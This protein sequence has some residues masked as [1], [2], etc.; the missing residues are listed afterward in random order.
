MGPV[1]YK[2]PFL[3][4]IASKIRPDLRGLS[5][6][7]SGTMVSPMMTRIPT[8]VIALAAIWVLAA[9]LRGQN[10]ARDVVVDLKSWQVDEIRQL[11]TLT[12]S[13]EQWDGIRKDF[14]GCPKRFD[15]VYPSDYDDCACGRT[16]ISVTQVNCSQVRVSL[17]LLRHL[18]PTGSLKRALKRGEDLQLSVDNRGQFYFGGNLV[19]FHQLLETIRDAQGEKLLPPPK[20]VNDDWLVIIRVPIELPEDSPVLATRLAEVESQISEIGGRSWVQGSE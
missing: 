18:S 1:S 3:R 9:D 13:A 7:I 6:S 10:P 17:G 19:P 8:G 20:N 15:A 11:G 12:L 4:L 2:L 5:F 14:P 16:G